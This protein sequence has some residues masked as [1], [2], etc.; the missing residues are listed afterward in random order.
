M[1]LGIL[2]GDGGSASASPCPSAL[3]AS[4]VLLEARLLTNTITPWP[5]PL[6]AP[7][8]S[9]KLRF[10]GTSFHFA[11]A[12]PENTSGPKIFATTAQVSNI[13]WSGVPCRP[14]TN[15]PTRCPAKGANF[16]A[17]SRATL[18][19]SFAR[20]PWAAASLA[21]ASAS[22][23]AIVAE[24]AASP[25]S[26]ER[27]KKSASLPLRMHVSSFAIWDSFHNSPDTPAATKTAP[28]SPKTKSVVLGRS[29]GCIVPR[30]KSRNSSKYSQTTKTTSSATPSATRDVQATN[31]LCSDELD[32]SR[33]ASALLSA[34]SSVM[35]LHDGQAHLAKIQLV[36]IIMLFYQTGLSH[37]LFR[38]SKLCRFFITILAPSPVYSRY[39]ASRI[40]GSAL[41]R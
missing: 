13:S 17:S 20:G 11:P 31:H 18:F 41:I 26:L 7:Q 32:S 34:D 1:R 2:F 8:P 36:V 23:R 21:T 38:I 27:I 16:P 28:S 4:I 19:N 40:C 39:P 35:E 6:A 12:V 29:G 24:V 15:N 30:L 10:V 9:A 5:N 3:A 33:V 37:D 22:L 14:Q 25:A